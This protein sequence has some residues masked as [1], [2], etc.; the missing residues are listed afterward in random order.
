[1]TDNYDISFEESDDPQARQTNESVYM[2]FSRDPVR[3][4]FQW[5]DSAFAGFTASNT[6]RTWLPVHAN[7]PEVNLKKQKEA[8]KSTFKLYQKLIQMRKDLNVLHIGG[9]ETKV[10]S[11]SLFGFMRTLRGEHTIAVFI[12]LGGA[13]KTSLKD[14][15]DEEEFQDNMKAKVLIVNN[16]STLEIGS[17]VDVLN[18][19]LGTYD[20]VVLEVSS[21][22]KLTVSLLLIVCTFVKFIF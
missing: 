11:P 4:P 13:V 14:L 6:Q 22:V 1:M 10:I 16:H 17:M 12:N 20:A 18:I 2:L 19:E 7:Y 8:E 5:D 21:G 15:M 3:T 9:L